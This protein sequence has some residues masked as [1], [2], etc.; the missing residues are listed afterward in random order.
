[1]Q[2]AALSRP[3][4]YTEDPFFSRYADMVFFL[5][6]L[7]TLSPL[8]VH[9][10]G[11]WAVLRRYDVPVR[12]VWL[13]LGPVL[14]RWRGL[15][16]GMLPIGGAVVPDMARY[17]ALHPGQ[18]MAVALAGPAASLLYGTVL[19]VVASSHIAV[20]N[21]KGLEI[22]AMLNFWLALLN[23]IPIP[24]LDGFKALCAW[25]ELRRSPLPDVLLH[26]ATRLG[27]GFVYGIGFFVLAKVFFM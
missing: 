25:Y 13:G 11:H 15:H 10:M 1:M 24:P 20:G 5:A 4:P 26:W 12:Q 2:Q 14:L 23:L 7:L 22:L 19:L 8:L 27:N 6:C 17:D 16:L 18:R 3:F 9:E 21:S